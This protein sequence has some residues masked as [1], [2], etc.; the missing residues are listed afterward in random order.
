M[1]KVLIAA[2]LVNAFLA[3]NSCSTSHKT[4]PLSALNGE[5]EIK[6]I[7][8]AAVVTSSEELP[9]LKF[10]TENGRLGGY[11]GCNRIMGSFETGS[12][13]GSIDLSNVGSTRMACPDMTTE[14]NLLNTLSQVKK[15]IQEDEETILMC[16]EYNR[17]VMT[18]VKKQKAETEQTVNTL[19]GLN[20]EWYITTINQEAVPAENENK[21]FIGFNTEEN[22]IYGNAGCN[23]FHGQFKTDENNGYFIQF[24]EV[25]NTMMM[26]PYMDTEDKI[27]KLLGEVRSF[28]Q[29][30]D[31]EYQFFNADNQEIL[32]IRKK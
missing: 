10:D 3:F 11:T 5:W 25:A 24:P 32:T 22:R 7:N 23:N 18:L 21:P 2:C 16:N 26:C 9:V 30:N 29:L 28:K 17:P 8:G 1:K 4:M 12:K 20:G 13:P 27:M 6:E 14:Q 19:A 15:Y 31:T